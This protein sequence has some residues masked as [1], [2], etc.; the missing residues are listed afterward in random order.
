MWQHSLCTFDIVRHY[1]LKLNTRYENLLHLPLVSK[2]RIIIMAS[3]FE[4]LFPP[5]KSLQQSSNDLITKE[6]KKFKINVSNTLP[7]IIILK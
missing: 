7:K 2:T 3:M 5:S 4:I 6:N 1:Q